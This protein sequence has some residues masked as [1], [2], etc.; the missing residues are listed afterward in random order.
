MKLKYVSIA[1]VLLCATS[2][3]FAGGA[4][5]L[6]QNKNVVIQDTVRLNIATEPDS[7]NPWISAASD[8]SAIF[9]NVFEGLMSYDDKG[10]LYPQICSSYTLS[11]DKLTYTFSI[12][13]DV[14]FHNGK[15]LTSDD[16]LFSYENF[17]EDSSSNYRFPIIESIST[18]DDY[19]YIVELKNP[20][21][22]FLISTTTLAI[23]PR[24]YDNQST[25]PI[26]TGPYKFVSYTPSQKM[27][28]VI[29]DKYYDESHMPS[30]KNVEV[31]IM[32]DTSSVV[33][34]LQSGQID[35]ADISSNNADLFKKDFTVVSGDRN[36]VTLL[37]LN[38][39]V[40]PLDDV[41]V[42]KALAMGINKKDVIDGVFDGYAD[43]VSSN[44]SPVFKEVYNEDL[45][46]SY[47]R[48]IEGAK[49]LLESAGYPNGLDLEITIPGIYWQHVDTAQIVQ[50]NLAEINVTVSIKTVE[51]G[52]WLDEVYYGR[53]YTSTIIGIDGKLDPFESLKRYETTASNNFM[54]Y[55]NSE[56]D[57]L[58]KK[59]ITSTEEQKVQIYKDAQRVVTED[60]G[61]AFICSP[62]NIVAMRSDLKGFKFYP[63]YFIDFS[64][65]YYVDAN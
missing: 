61:C 28:F 44:L 25:K 15:H 52:T 30:I 49:A 51:W 48:D 63:V 27:V 50:Q 60:A 20:S 57:S 45:E 6:K 39:D 29:N 53:D 19:T 65:L 35:V 58:I 55:S 34:A 26:G 12:R 31:Y 42:R 17:S 7:L 43:P 38:N 9:N 23:L 56:Y 5:E 47:D 8:T 1:L 3:A 54:N 64:S 14:Y 4:N 16:V 40:A 11:D 37:V 10:T 21:S 36:M 24:G 22:S 41:R 62:K 59:A 13:E 32:S 2:F 18:P 33:A 46:G